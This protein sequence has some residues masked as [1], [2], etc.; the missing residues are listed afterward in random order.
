MNAAFYGV[1]SEV[2]KLPNKLPTTL[3]QAATG[4]KRATAGVGAHQ[5]MALANAITAG[6]YL[7]YAQSQFTSHRDP[8]WV[9][10]REDNFD[11]S[12]RTAREYTQ[13][14]RAYA[15]SRG[16]IPPR[17][18]LPHTI[19]SAYEWARTIDIPKDL[20][21]V[22]SDYGKDPKEIEEREAKR[23]RE[24]QELE[25]FKRDM[26][27]DK[28]KKREEHERRE[29]EEQGEQHGVGR[30]SEKLQEQ[31]EPLARKI[32]GLIRKALSSTEEGER[33][34]FIDKAAELLAKHGLTY[35]V[36]V[37]E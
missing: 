25:K 5:R 20:P 35:D 8:K 3:A 11:G 32:E 14:A 17:E 16:D 9:K 21:A 22:L 26:Q 29:R 15:F 13:I 30:E 6:F 12:D 24:E 19:E 36:V 34:V 27:R 37:S 28:Q 2:I 31:S 4:L 18:N 23:L 1:S 7:H 10:W 33:H